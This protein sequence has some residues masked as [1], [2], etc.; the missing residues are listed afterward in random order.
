MQTNFPL[1]NQSHLNK[2]ISH[3]LTKVTSYIRLWF[4]ISVSAS[5]EANKWC[6]WKLAQ[7]LLNISLQLV[8]TSV[9][10][11]I[12]RKSRWWYFPVIFLCNRVLHSGMDQSSRG[13]LCIY[14][15]SLSVMCLGLPKKF[16]RH[17]FLFKYCGQTIYSELY[18]CFEESFFN[19]LRLLPEDLKLDFKMDRDV[20][21]FLVYHC[22]RDD[23]D[24]FVV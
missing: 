10:G 6:G 11:E 21:M 17:S 16:L 8:H 2:R 1:V 5:D 13:V 7:C 12:N 9:Q 18:C 4:F 22:I 14:L 20:G 19:L 24:I 23:L 15:M 3:L